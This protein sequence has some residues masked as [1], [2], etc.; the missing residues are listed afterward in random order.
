[1]AV[2]SPFRLSEDKCGSIAVFAPGGD[3]WVTASGR[4]ET[5][6]NGSL[7]TGPG[8]RV[9]KEGDGAGPSCSSATAAAR[10]IGHREF[11]TWRGE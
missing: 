3:D 5:D 1:M 8:V 11:F 9:S 2:A 7:A 10:F 6:A 4:E